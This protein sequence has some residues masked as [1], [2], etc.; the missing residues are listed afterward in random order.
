MQLRDSAMALRMAAAGAFLLTTT[1]SLHA[2]SGNAPESIA[3]IAGDQRSSIRLV[4]NPAFRKFLSGKI[5]YS[6]KTASLG[7]RGGIDTDISTNANR[8]HDPG[9]PG[10]KPRGQGV[11]GSHAIEF[12]NL[13]TRAD[14]E[15][16]RGELFTDVSRA[17]KCDDKMCADR[18]RLS[19]FKTSLK[20]RFF[21]KLTTVNRRVNRKIKYVPDLQLFGK[22]DH[23]AGPAQ[24]ITRGAG[25][26]EDYALLKMALLADLGVPVRSMSLVVLKD[27]RR[28]LY[29]AVLSVSTNKGN[30]I[31]DNVRDDVILDSKLAHYKPLYSYSDNRSWIHGMPAGSS[32]RLAADQ[33]QT[34]AEI[35]PGESGYVVTAFRELADVHIEGIEPAGANNLLLRQ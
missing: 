30:F 20:K 31:L 2:G 6:V 32:N 1:A 9:Q 24:T 10:P 4:T 34:F 21:D 3:D 11:F 27:R 13:A 5:D 35:V 15:K 12:R 7:L 19:E 16:H 22:L 26:C 29:H 23:W 25:D 8:R 33:N 14:W 28:N 18:R 17:S